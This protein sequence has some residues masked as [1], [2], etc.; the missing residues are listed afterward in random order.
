MRLIIRR[1][2]KVL[3][4]SNTSDGL[5]CPDDFVQPF[6]DVFQFLYER[7]VAERPVQGAVGQRTVDITG[8][9]SQ[10]PHRILDYQIGFHLNRVEPCSISTEL[11]ESR[12]VN[13]CVSE[14]SIAR[15]ENL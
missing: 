7:H 11:P 2:G 15:E 12:Q 5:L 6:N 8:F 1:E 4:D 10:L 9:S 13:I 3:L 14:G